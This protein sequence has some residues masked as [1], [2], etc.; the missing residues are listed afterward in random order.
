MQN[1]IQKTRFGFTIN[2]MFDALSLDQKANVEDF[3]GNL[4]ASSV[5]VESVLR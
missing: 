1:F 4:S 3:L 2:S 5:I